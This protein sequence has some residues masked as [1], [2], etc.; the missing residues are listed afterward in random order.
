MSIQEKTKALFK[1]QLTSWPLLG[2][3]WEKHGDAQIKQFDFDGYSIKVQCNPKR[4][5]S[6]AAKVD[7][8]SIEKRPCFLCTEHRPP[9]EKN[10]WFGERYEILCNPFPIFR[11]HF[12]IAKSDHT[13]QVIEPEFGYFLELSRALPDLALFYNAPNCGASAPDH[14]HF[15]AG[16]RGF[17]PI[18]EQ[19]ATLKL[20]YG[21]LL[22]EDPGI[23]ILAVA[24]GLRR[25]YVLESNS[26]EILE[27]SAAIAFQMIRELQNGAEPMINMLS[28]YDQGWQVLLFPRDKH[29][30]WQYFEEGEKNILLSPASV[31]MGGALITPL[32]KD[33]QKITREDIEDIFSQL[34]FSAE[35]FERMNEYLIHKLE[36]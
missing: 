9:E 1:D 22:H 27:E 35:N 28:Y 12:T 26:K 30:P 23:K 21:Q 34:T 24:D 4:I 25:F 11:E 19:I 15:Q 18:E 13:P 31:D 7:K 6:S 33:F 14:M 5:V 2:A 36:R 29:R 3:N 17:M 16:N 10:V 32:E 20:R 8:V